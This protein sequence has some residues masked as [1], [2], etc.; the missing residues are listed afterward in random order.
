VPSSASDVSATFSFMSAQW[1]Q[2]PISAQQDTDSQPFAA[3]LDANTTG[4]ET[5]TAPANPPLPNP[6]Q[7]AAPQQASFAF[8]ATWQVPYPNRNAVG[9]ADSSIPAA[10]TTTG[11]ENLALTA[12]AGS[13]PTPADAGGAATTATEVGSGQAAPGRWLMRYARLQAANGDNSTAALAQG[14]SNAGPQAPSANDA[15]ATTPTDGKRSTTPPSANDVAAEANPG[16][17][18]NNPNPGPNAA[19]SDV[20]SASVATDQPSATP[21]FWTKALRDDGKD[22]AGNSGGTATAAVSN[23]S[24]PAANA[25]QPIAAVVVVSA[26]AGNAPTASGTPEASTTI[27]EPGR[28]HAR[29]TATTIGNQGASKT[30]DVS[31][32]TATKQAPAG[33]QAE[34]SATSTSNSSSNDNVSANPAAAQPESTQGIDDNAAPQPGGS[35]PTDTDHAAGQPI[36][37][38]SAVSAGS[39]AGSSATQSV[40]GNAK[41]SADGLANFGFS[42]SVT[43]ASSTATTSAAGSPPAPA[44]PIAGLAISIA[45]RAQAGSNQFD[46]RLDP[47]E[48]GRIDVHLDFDRNGQVTTHLTAD[49]A[50]TLNLLQSQQPQLEQALQQAGLKT[51]DN[52]LQFTL[53]DQSFAGQQNGNG[54]GSQSSNS[55]QLV[56]PDPDLTP[57]AATQIYTRLDRG[58][59]VDIRV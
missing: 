36:D 50:D 47:P 2:A 17:I 32:A 10:T 15:P 40:M 30:A 1:P 8:G 24:Q 23:Q 21:N 4:L 37:L 45:A 56:I 44:V 6:S 43:T 12:T 3:L 35:G 49:R 14:S 58:S 7:A 41:T 16:G 26:S 52:G 59:G 28:G 27:G 31:T 19:S 13:E 9:E 34:S 46:I 48:L 5:M 22:T 29:W 54:S 38:S 57:V 55:A 11:A 39:G 42:P 33:A 51:A 53:R 25:P 18:A 20:A